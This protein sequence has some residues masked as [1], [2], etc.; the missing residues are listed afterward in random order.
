[1]LGTDISF[2][3]DSLQNPDTSRNQIPGCRCSICQISNPPMS[4][5]DP[6]IGD[7]LGQQTGDSSL[8]P[9]G[10][11]SSAHAI[12]STR[13]CGILLPFQ[14]M[15]T[16]RWGETPICSQGFILGVSVLSAADPRICAY[17]HCNCNC[18]VQRCAGHGPTAALF[19]V[20]LSCRSITSWLQSAEWLAAETQ[21]TPYLNLSFSQSSGTHAQEAPE[22]LAVRNYPR[23]AKT[24]AKRSQNDALAPAQW[25]P[26]T[27]AC[28][29]LC[30]HGTASLL[31]R[32]HM[33]SP[34]PGLSFVTASQCKSPPRND[35]K[36]LVPWQAL[37]MAVPLAAGGDSNFTCVPLAAAARNPNFPLPELCL[38]LLAMGTGLDW[39]T[40]DNDMM[41]P[42]RHGKPNKRHP[43]FFDAHGR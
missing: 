40:T 31:Q 29:P 21:S 38:C 8:G 36:R 3:L 28:A 19:A 24:A 20:S 35:V 10:G 33:P 5:S 34:S 22:L 43:D 27:V 17:E 26:S 42:E 14:A 18:T 1:T 25:L 15:G 39:A 9:K 30:S 32:D 11:A 37:G 23:W 16:G 6:R 12:D 41:A 4:C 7:P 13:L 2:C